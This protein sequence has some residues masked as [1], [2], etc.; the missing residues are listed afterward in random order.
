M[1]DIRQTIA[2]ISGHRN[3]ECYVVLYYAVKVARRYHPQ[4]PRMKTIIAETAVLMKYDKS[5]AAL[6]RSLSRVNTDIWEYGD[7]QELQEIFGYALQEQPTPRELVF[8]LAEYT[9]DGEEVRWQGQRITYR[10]WKSLSG[11]EY[12]IVAM[13]REP[14]YRA[15]TCP[16]C[17]DLETGRQLVRRLNEEQVPL[18]AFEEMY[19]SGALLEW[20]HRA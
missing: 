18:A 10:L 4:E 14:A 8:R 15:V 19:L 11:A 1:K 17:R 2:R 12:G 7:R 3:R 20:N 16:F 5:S 13:L 6:S 9:R